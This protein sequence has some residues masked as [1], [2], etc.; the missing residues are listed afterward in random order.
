MAHGQGCKKFK[1][2]V[3]WDKNTK[4]TENTDIQYVQRIHVEIDM[5]INS[6]IVR[7]TSEKSIV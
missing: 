7:N 3:I 2:F 1:T 5:E 4:K 6:L